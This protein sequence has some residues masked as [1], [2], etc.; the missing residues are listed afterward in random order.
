MF[1]APRLAGTTNA[2]RPGTDKYSGPVMEEPQPILKTLSLIEAARRF[3]SRHLLLKP[4]C[5]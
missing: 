1:T 4:V 5:S 3:D 2:E